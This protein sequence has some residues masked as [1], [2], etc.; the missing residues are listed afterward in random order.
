M[1]SVDTKLPRA[2]L[3]KVL[4][5]DGYS[6]DKTFTSGWEKA[7]GY[8]SVVGFFIAEGANSATMEIEQSIDGEEVDIVD[9]ESGNSQGG[10]STVAF[11]YSLVG[12]QVRVNAEVTGSPSKVRILVYRTTRLSA[13]SQV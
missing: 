10:G 4:E 12:N 3:L 1:G 8:S 13:I 2:R 9:S 7:F 6:G 5:S 11:E